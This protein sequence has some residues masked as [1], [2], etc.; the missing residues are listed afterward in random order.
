ML[1]NTRESSRERLESSDGKF[2]AK[3]QQA[4]EQEAHEQE[5]RVEGKL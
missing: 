2:K 5:A 3:A 4:H 1:E